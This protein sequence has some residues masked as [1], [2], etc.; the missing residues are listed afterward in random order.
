MLKSLIN[1]DLCI[2]GNIECKSDIEVFGSVT[3]DINANMVIVQDSGRVV[4]KVNAVSVEIHGSLKGAL[5]VVS[6]KIHSQAVVEASIT[7][8]ELGSDKGARI[9]GKIN[10]TGSKTTDQM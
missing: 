6:V 10:I 5:S 2:V 8:E 1:E 3:G 7:A 9:A 4:G